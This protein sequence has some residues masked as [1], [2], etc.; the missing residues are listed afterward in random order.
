MKSPTPG[1]LP[2]LTGLGLPDDLPEIALD[3]LPAPDAAAVARI[4]ART[5]QLALAVER[6]PIEPDL[7]H[8]QLPRAVRRRVPRWAVAIAALLALVLLVSAV[9][10]VRAAVRQ[11]LTFVPGFGL[12]EAS[13]FSLAAAGTVEI[14]RDGITVAVRGLVADEKS[15]VAAITVDGII[16]LP[17]DAPYLE[18]A[19]GHRYTSGPGSVLTAGGHGD[20]WMQAWL[21]FQPPLPVDLRE[22]TVVIPGTPDWRLNVPLVPAADLTALEQFGPTATANG[23]TMAARAEASA[24]TTK[25]TLLVQGLPAD[26]SLNC[27][28]RMMSDLPAAREPELVTPDGHRLPLRA[29]YSSSTGLRELTAGV[30]ARSQATVSIPVIRLSKSVSAKAHVPVPA[31]GSSLSLD[32]EVKVDRWTVRLT[33]VEACEES[34]GHPILKVWVDPGPTEALMLADVGPISVDGKPSSSSTQIN[35]ETGRI[36]WFAVALPDKR[37]AEIG[38]SRVDLEL[39]GP[40]EI[41]VPVGR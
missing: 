15:I 22:V 3:D 4:K 14:E 24:D 32:T 7:T 20:G 35:G 13:T 37:S 36:V 31:F 41:T 30:A 33:R 10:P 38:F 29:T 9:P 17:T 2:D 1:E 21:S 26:T 25:V 5:L 11:L 6:Q 8:P 39:A 28:G 12:R 34:P 16:P 27:L 23:V 18:D 19:S 40:W